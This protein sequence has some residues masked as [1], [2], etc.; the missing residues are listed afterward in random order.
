MMTSSSGAQLLVRPGILRA[1][2]T[3]ESVIASLAGFGLGVAAGSVIASLAGFNRPH[4]PR[5]SNGYAGSPQVRTRRLSTNAGRL[6][7]PPKTPVEPT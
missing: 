2:F 1:A 7:D 3:T 6:L 4:R 5:R